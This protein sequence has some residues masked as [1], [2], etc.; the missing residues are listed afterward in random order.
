MITLIGFRCTHSN[1]LSH[2][3]LIRPSRPET[4]TSQY[5]FAQFTHLNLFYFTESWKL[6]CGIF[7]C[8]LSSMGSGSYDSG[9]WFESISALL[10]SRVRLKV[11]QADLIWFP[12][13]SRGQAVLRNHLKSADRE[14]QEYP[15]GCRCR[16]RPRE[17][18]QSAP[19]FSFQDWACS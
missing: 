19:H 6:K 7:W 14:S 18:F 3:V 2:E 10:F 5:M 8:A 16:V 11:S 1:V 17:L 9:W 15:G 4:Q 13:S 12:S